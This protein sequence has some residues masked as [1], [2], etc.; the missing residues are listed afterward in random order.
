MARR[1]IGVPAGVGGGDSGSGSGADGD[2]ERPFYVLASISDIVALAMFS[3]FASIED[4]RATGFE[5]SLPMLILGGVFTIIATFFMEVAGAV[6][7]G[8]NWFA[9][10]YVLGWRRILAFL[11][12]CLFIIFWSFGVW[13]VDPAA[14]DNPEMEKL[15]AKTSAPFV[16]V[17]IAI[18]WTAQSLLYWE[19]RIRPKKEPQVLPDQNMNSRPSPKSALTASLETEVSMLKEQLA[20][21]NNRVLV[22]EMAIANLANGN[23]TNASIIAPYNI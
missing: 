5:Y 12:Q 9:L 19:I 1:E 6:K 16:G 21:V 15:E 7:C 18:S 13:S 4:P 14:E 3:V 17:L 8:D 10:S 2:N 22:L 23:N 20:G 11:L